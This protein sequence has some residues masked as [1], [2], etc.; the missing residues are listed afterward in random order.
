M[1]LRALFVSLLVGALTVI[2][3]GA[4]MK[5]LEVETSGGTPV[6][7]LVAVKPIEPG[8]VLTAEMVAT[9]PVPQAF[10]ES[11]AVKQGDLSRVIGLKVETGI[12]PQQTL[13]WTDLAVAS[14]DR[15]QLSALVQ[16]GM[17]AV[18]I[19]SGSGDRYFANIRP[20]DRVDVVANVPG[21]RDDKDRIAVL[22]AQNVLVLAVG[23][24]TGGASD[25]IAT[26]APA[27][28]RGE[29]VL[30]VG[31]N[32]QQLQQISLAQE[33]GK[34]TVGLRNP[35]DARPLEGVSDMTYASIFGGA[36]EKKEAPA[37]IRPTALTGPR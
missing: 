27:T 11:R 4:Y 18:G 29:L 23:L 10:V 16:P 14:D 13:L 15:R 36:P 33:R 3:L 24:D 9:R 31:V 17:R 20:G 21:A 2:L 19:R 37:P 34:L 30:T 6:R 7:V 12:K 5:R 32:M 28:D 8:T 1:K 22:V 26:R 35:D 25:A